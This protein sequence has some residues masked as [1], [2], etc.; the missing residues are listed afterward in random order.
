MRCWSAVSTLVT[1][2]FFIISFVAA[3]L[4]VA[5]FG[6][7][8][9]PQNPF[10]DMDNS[11]NN[12]MT[13]DSGVPIV[14]DALS[15]QRDVSIFSE[16]VR[17]LT[18]H[19]ILDRLEDKGQNTTVLAPLNSA[20]R[21]LPRKPWEDPDPR[22]NVEGAFFGHEGE[23]KAAANLERFVKAHVVPVSPFKENEKVQT[24][25]GTTVWW[26]TENGIT[27]LYPGGIEVKE[28]KSPVPNGQIWTLKGVVPY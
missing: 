3:V 23:K 10:V 21:A 22:N 25:E 20:M 2:A 19:Q 12:P 18:N 24:L 5:N 13:G 11:Q 14:S 6:P 28:V 8:K 16:I 4:P 7:S 9:N 27:K 1:F 17:G 15:V 26:T